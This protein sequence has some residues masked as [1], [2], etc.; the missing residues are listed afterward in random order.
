MFVFLQQA[1]GKVNSSL[2][3]SLLLS[4]LAVPV[5]VQ[6][7]GCLRLFESPWTAARLAGFALKL[8]QLF[9]V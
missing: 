5:V 6:L 9:T 7:L 8:L 1:S 2:I 4:L 3:F